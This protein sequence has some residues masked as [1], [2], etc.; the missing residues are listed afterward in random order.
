MHEADLIGRW[1]GDCAALLQYVPE[2]PPVKEDHKRLLMLLHDLGGAAVLVHLLGAL[3]TPLLGAQALA[4]LAYFLGQGFGEWNRKTAFSRALAKAESSADARRQLEAVELL[5]GSGLC[6]APTY[7]QDAAPSQ[8]DEENDMWAQAGVRACAAFL[9]RG[10][11]VDE[12]LDL[13]RDLVVPAPTLHPFMSAFEVAARLPPPIATESTSAAPTRFALEHMLEVLEAAL[14]QPQH[15]LASEGNLLRWQL[16]RAMNFGQ[17]FAPAPPLACPPAQP[18]P[19]WRRRASSSPCRL[20][21][22]S[23]PA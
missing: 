6:K 13:V 2:H 9:L 3:S 5:R 22:A 12:A 20:S 4:E 7:A 11:R 23:A 8:G 19:R 18:M 14:K 10:R 16:R 17:P 15:G 21:R 1:V